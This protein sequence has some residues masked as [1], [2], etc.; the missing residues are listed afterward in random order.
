MYCVSCGRRISRG[1]LL[2]WSGHCDQCADRQEGTT[3][4]ER[5][6]AA[7]MLRL[8]LAFARGTTPLV[9]DAAGR[10]YLYEAVD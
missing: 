7:R 9:Y 10:A 2:L 4:A 6:Y 8:A 1:E 3:P 5:A